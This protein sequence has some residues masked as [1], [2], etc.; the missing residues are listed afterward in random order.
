MKEI[1]LVGR[2]SAII[3]SLRNCMKV[4]WLGASKTLLQQQSQEVTK[5]TNESFINILYLK[6]A[7]MKI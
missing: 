1:K 2:L 3:P 6:K 4:Y 7:P 5:V